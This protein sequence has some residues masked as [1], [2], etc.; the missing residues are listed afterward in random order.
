VRRTPLSFW[1]LIGLLAFSVGLASG[2]QDNSPSGGGAANPPPGSAPARGGGAPP[3]ADEG[4]VQSPITL[5]SP[6]A[7]PKKQIF[8]G[9]RQ[10]AVNGANNT[11]PWGHD[12][13]GAPLNL[14]F[15]HVHYHD[16]AEHKH[17]DCPQPDVIEIHYVYAN[18]DRQELLGNCVAPLVV[19]A[20]LAK[21]RGM[22]DPKLGADVNMKPPVTPE[23]GSWEYHGSTTGGTGGASPAFWHVKKGCYS[24]SDADR[25]RLHQP[26]DAPR[27][28]QDDKRP[29]PSITITNN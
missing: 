29:R 26:P 6:P 3:P 4:I 19:V 11:V 21:K 2:C 8:D 17:P 27:P 25:G 12:P 16:P 28:L 10:V 18:S 23:K 15:C 20:V 13:A 22:T 1:C 9:P 14:K 24:I 7:D 5:P